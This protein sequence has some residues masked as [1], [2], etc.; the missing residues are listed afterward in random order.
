MKRCLVTGACGFIGSH[1]VKLLVSEGYEV[2][3]TDLEGSDQSIIPDS[4]DFIPSD[5]TDKKTL[6]EVLKGIDWVF[7]TAALFDHKAPWRTLK[8]VNIEGMKNICRAAVNTKIKRFISW[9]T[10]GVYD[11]RNSGKPSADEDSPKNP[12]TDYEKSKLGQEKIGLTFYKRYNLPITIIRPALVYGIRSKYG[13]MDIILKINKAPILPV[14]VNLKNKVTC[15]HVKDVC[16]AALFV[17][18]KKRAIGEAYNIVDGT[19]L[20]VKQ[21]TLFIASLLSKPVFLFYVP[22]PILI[23]LANFNADLSALLDKLIFKDGRYLI[24]KPLVNYIRY[25]YVFSNEKIK[26]LG[27]KFNYPDYR[28][29]LLE[30][31]KWYRKKKLL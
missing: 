19:P 6:P 12:L 5:L 28:I 25:D 27:F 8:K 14:P 23:L 18:G 17:A 11:P 29:G 1:L 16:R 31:I 24:E 7:H 3:A 2:R 26:K 21:F 15:V 22:V 4:V 20:D 13:L 30:T 10:M 9:S